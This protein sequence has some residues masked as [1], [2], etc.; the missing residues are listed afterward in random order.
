MAPGQSGVQEVAQCSC[1]RIPLFPDYDFRLISL[2]ASNGY[3]FPLTV[4][5]VTLAECEIGSLG[6]KATNRKSDWELCG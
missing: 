2:R 6:K 3:A 1:L 4:S 5:H